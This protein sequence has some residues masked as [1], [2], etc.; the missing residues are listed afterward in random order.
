MKLTDRLALAT[1]RRR[2]LPEGPCATACLQCRTDG[3]AVGLEV[4]SWLEERYGYS[5]PAEL[6]RGVCE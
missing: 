6:L 2:L 5:E 3:M 4:A 1:C